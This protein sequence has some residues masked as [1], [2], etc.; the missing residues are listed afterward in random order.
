M[1]GEMRQKTIAVW[2]ASAALA[3]V[4]LSALAQ[5]GEGPNQK[6]HTA[7]AQPASATLMVMCD[8]ACNWRLDG[9]AKGLIEFGS[10]GK[11]KVELGQHIVTGETVNGLDRVENEIE[12]KTTG[13]TIVRIALLPVRR[14]RLNAEQDAQNKVDQTAKDNAAR[15]EQEKVRQEAERNLVTNQAVID[16]VAAQLPDGVIIAKIRA[17]KT[18]FDLSAPALID[19]NKRG[20]PA[21]VVQVMINPTADSS[22]PAAPKQQPSPVADPNDPASPHAPGIYLAEGTGADRKL[23][24]LDACEFATKNFGSLAVR[25][26]AVADRPQAKIR[27]PNGQPEFYFY[28]DPRGASR[29]P[30]TMGTA[31][32]PPDFM[33]LRLTVNSAG[34]REAQILKPGFASFHAADSAVPF[35]STRIGPA[36]YRVTL[37]YPLEAGEYGFLSFS[38][39]NK[40]SVSSLAVGIQSKGRHPLFWLYDFGVR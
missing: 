2:A 14:A 4:A 26:G 11:A 33:L 39:D 38:P 16:M 9:E 15:E 32:S 40:A 20:V 17:S 1:E 21:A 37:P 23:I 6:P 8:L 22:A 25:P 28:F 3:V 34:N 36:A 29:N 24:P 18:K 5:P 31:G 19:L 10:S 13:Q 30:V 7:Q 35:N 27:V 12:I